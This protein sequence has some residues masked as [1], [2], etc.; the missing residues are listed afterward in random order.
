MSNLEENSHSCVDLNVKV[1]DGTEEFR[2]KTETTGCNSDTIFYTMSWGFLAEKLPV[3]ST[4]TKNVW[5]KQSDSL[6]YFPTLL[7]F[8]GF[9]T[10]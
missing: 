5:L 3:L 6:L 1:D 2:C 9:L 4:G 7:D 10:S 8:G